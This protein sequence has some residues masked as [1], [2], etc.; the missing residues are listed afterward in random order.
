MEKITFDLNRNVLF[1]HSFI[2]AQTVVQLITLMKGSEPPVME[3]HFS[4]IENK[5]TP[6]P[7]NT[8]PNGIWHRTEVDQKMTMQELVD[9]FV[10]LED[11]IY[12]LNLEDICVVNQHEKIDQLT[13][14][15]RPR[16]TQ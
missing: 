9:R 7:V 4:M 5:V 3:E 16:N 8:D 1:V 2:A 12:I 15:Y 11:E 10:R 6:R 13:E 14:R